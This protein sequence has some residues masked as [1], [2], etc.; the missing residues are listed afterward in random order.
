M[1]NIYS[2]IYSFNKK[3]LK[4]T[5]NS[6]K[7]GN[8]VSLPTETVYGL[9]A[10]A[11]SKKAVGKIFKLKKRPKKNPLIIHYYRLKD[12][13]K[14]VI[15][16]EYRSIPPDLP[17][18]PTFT[19]LHFKGSCPHTKTNKMDTH[20][21]SSLASIFSTTQVFK[22]RAVFEKAQKANNKIEHY[23]MDVAKVTELASDTLNSAKAIW[24]KQSKYTKYLSIMGR[25]QPS[26]TPN[27]V[28]RIANIK[29]PKERLQVDTTNL[30]NL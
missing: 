16:N 6:L 25:A 1:K 23:T 13:K 28:C 21:R 7:A 17:V 5:V 18:F 29:N 19:S 24:N 30:C 20:E 22:A 10:S 8:I 26:F 12:L 15:L 9:A 27:T 3:I 2:N 14:D 4:K 11:Y